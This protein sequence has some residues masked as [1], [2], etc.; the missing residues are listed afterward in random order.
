MNS[1]RES[2]TP[3]PAPVEEYLQQVETG[4]WRVC[5]EQKAL[6]KYIRRTFER[7]KLIFEAERFEK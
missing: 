4:P 6:A 7:E 5:P 3:I 2:G 1:E